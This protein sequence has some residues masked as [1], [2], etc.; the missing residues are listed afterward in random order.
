MQIN[1]SD[2]LPEVSAK[3]PNGYSSNAK[4]QALNII[5]ND[6]SPIRQDVE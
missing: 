5:L 4:T 1:I 2:I 3:L 6:Q